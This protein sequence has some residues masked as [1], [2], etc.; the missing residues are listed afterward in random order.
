MLL[1]CVER[2]LTCRSAAEQCLRSD[3]LNSLPYLGALQLC[4]SRSF[5][6]GKI[7]KNQIFILML[8]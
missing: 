5:H 4:S 3:F 2:I 1:M 6:S 7:L 8:T